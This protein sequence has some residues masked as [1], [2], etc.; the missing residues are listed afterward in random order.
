M[1]QEEIVMPEVGMEASALVQP[2]ATTITTIDQFAELVSQW[3]DNRQKAVKY[4]LT[5]PDGVEFER[6][7]GP[8][9]P[10]EKMLMTGDLMKGFKFGVELALMQ[11]GDLP[12][13]AELE[14]Q[15]ALAEAPVPV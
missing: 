6:A 10:P 13:V 12:F 9:Q 7:S 5:V 14:D 15:Q 8:D 11:L 1:I 2:E 4:L 3:Y